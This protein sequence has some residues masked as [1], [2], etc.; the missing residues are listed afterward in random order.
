[1]LEWAL[2][3]SIDP[4]P[5]PTPWEQ[6][7]ATHSQT[8][9]PG[10]QIWKKCQQQLLPM[11]ISRPFD[12]PCLVTWTVLDTRSNRWID[13]CFESPLDLCRCY[14]ASS[15]AVFPALPD[16]FGSASTSMQLLGKT[17]WLW[18]QR[19]LRHKILCHGLPLFLPLMGYYLIALDSISAQSRA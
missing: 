3:H 19:L 16:L 12:L 4:A 5:V 15:L 1:M 17:W 7:A 9:T 11:G 14:T 18:M 6:T 2:T 8:S 10:S 13:K